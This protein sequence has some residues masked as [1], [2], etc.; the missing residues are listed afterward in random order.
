MLKLFILFFISFLSIHCKLENTNSYLNLS[1]NFMN[2]DPVGKK[3]TTYAAFYQREPL[4]KFINTKKEEVFTANITNGKERYKVGCGLWKD[5][6]SSHEI[7]VF[8]NIGENIKAG[9]YYILFNETKPFKFEDFIV[10][11][12]LDRGEEYLKFEK[13]DKN[14]IDLYADNQNLTIEDKVDSYELKFNIV[15]L[16]I[17]Q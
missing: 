1:F 13:V 11:L 17:M 16:K 14:F 7:K 4:Q 15:K 2:D 5:D 9:N 8:C 12:D 3:G 10:V 6:E